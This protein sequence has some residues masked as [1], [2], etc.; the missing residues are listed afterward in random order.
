MI[1]ASTQ[2]FGTYHTCKKTPCML[3]HFSRVLQSADF[4]THKKKYFR[5]LS[6][7]HT[8]WIQ[9]RSNIQLGLIWPD[10]GPN[11]LWWSAA[12]D[13]FQQVDASIAFRQEM[14]QRMIL[15]VQ[16]KIF[17]LPFFPPFQ[18]SYHL[19]II[20]LI[21][22]QIRLLHSVWSEFTAWSNVNW[23]SFEYMH[24]MSKTEAI[25]RTKIYWQ[26]IIR[27]YVMGGSS[28]GCLVVF[29]AFFFFHKILS[30]GGGRGGFLTTL[31]FYF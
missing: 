23:R 30:E 14:I 25:F 19:L 27:I 29:L 26:D 8:D 3:G 12:D 22:T 1:Q 9:I 6:E 17:F 24:Q 4:F 11:C 15:G 5:T 20:Q 16:E 21:W 13:K 18:D 2:A 28:Q 31:Y 10:L 7:C